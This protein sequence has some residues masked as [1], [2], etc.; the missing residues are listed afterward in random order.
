MAFLWS[1]NN[2]V[3]VDEEFWHR[4][5][6]PKNHPDYQTPKT[7]HARR[8]LQRVAECAYGD[9]TGEPGIINQHLLISTADGQDKGA[10]RSGDYVGSNRYQ[11]K[12]E[13]RTYLQRIQKIVRGKTNAFIVNPC[14]A[15][16]TSDTEIMTVLGP[17]PVAEL[18]EGAFDAL[19]NG[20]AVRA[21]AF[22]TSGVVPIYEIVT[23]EGCRLKCSAE[24]RLFRYYRR[25]PDY[26]LS[27]EIPACRVAVGDR[28]EMGNHRRMEVCHEHP[29]FDVG[30]AVGHIKGNGGHNPGNSSGTYLRF[31]H[32]EEYDLE[33]RA[34]ALV[35]SLGV[36]G[37][38]SGGYH[39]RT[40]GTWTI[41]SEQLSRM[42]DQYLFPLTKD[43][44]P[45]LLHGSAPLVA[46][47]LQGFFDSDGSPQGNTKKGRS[48]RLNQ[49]ND[50]E[51][52]KVQQMLLRFGIMSKLV[53]RCAAGVRLMPDGRGGQKLYPHKEKWE[54]IIQMIILRNTLE[55]LDF[56]YL[57]RWRL[58]SASHLT[59]PERQI[60]R[61]FS[62]G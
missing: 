58:L 46:G 23:A 36:S 12:D 25:G 47:F 13:T 3:T 39:N 1:S 8:V 5:R 38:Y 22:R 4:V 6:L 55:K 7:Q 16:V 31:W 62:L 52:L 50:A 27:E 32:G 30:W 45:A 35:R 28:L 20:K 51:L 57:Q 40:N 10:F 48:V 61:I 49:S 60:M 34:D 21:S 19:V 59:C 33:L 2:S 9:G 24:H 17:R 14:G 44:R 15:C 56:H 18:M 26:V 43:I 29:D 54:I 11:V 42:V 41:R 37:S 53:R